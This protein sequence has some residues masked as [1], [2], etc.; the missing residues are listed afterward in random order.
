MFFTKTFLALVSLAPA[1]VT[2]QLGVTHV[3]SNDGTVEYPCEAA[4]MAEVYYQDKC[5]SSHG[6]DYELDDC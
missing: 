5:E 1:L 2:A 3:M 4:A 6:V